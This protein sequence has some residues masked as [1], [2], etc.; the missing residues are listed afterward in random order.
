MG[1]E[2]AFLQRGSANSGWE[3]SYAGEQVQWYVVV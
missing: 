1:T 2:I 3:R